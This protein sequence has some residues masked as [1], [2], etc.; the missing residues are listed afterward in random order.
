MLEILTTFEMIYT[1]EFY[2][3]HVMKESIERQTADLF[4]AIE[5]KFTVADEITKAKEAKELS[6]DFNCQIWNKVDA[7]SHN[8]QYASH[9]LLTAMSPATFLRQWT[10]NH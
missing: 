8:I 2:T 10:V 6:Q 4:L 7:Q 1:N 5:N 9:A 3:L